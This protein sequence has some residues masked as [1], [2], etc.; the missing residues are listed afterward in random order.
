MATTLKWTA[1][2]SIATALTTELDGLAAAA[3]AASS[4]VANETGLYPYIDLEL[5]LASVNYSAA[6]GLAVYVWFLVQPDATNYEDG[7]ASVIPARSPDAIFQLRLVNG[8]QRVVINNIPVPPLD[9]T[10]LLQNNVSAAFA[11][12]SNTL[13]YRRHYLQSV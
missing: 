13:K 9:F 2:E 12:N 1:P 5:Y 8:A 10:I 4:E 3:L 11:A 6:T 7:S